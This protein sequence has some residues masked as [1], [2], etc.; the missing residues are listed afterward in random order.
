[1]SST[2]ICK[3]SPHILKS[4]QNRGSRLEAKVDLEV[5]ICKISDF[6]RFI[7]L[8]MSL[9]IFLECLAENPQ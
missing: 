2:K 4:Q 8:V 5:K 1:M 6:H 9:E 7:R 3:A